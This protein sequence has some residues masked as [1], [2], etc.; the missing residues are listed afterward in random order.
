MMTMIPVFRSLQSCLR[1]LHFKWC[2]WLLIIPGICS[3]SGAFGQDEAHSGLQHRALD[4]LSKHCLRCHSSDEAAGEFSLQ[5][6]RELFASGYVEPGSVENSHLISV[7][8]PEGDSPPSMPKTGSALTNEEVEWLRKWIA[9]GAPFP[10]TVRLT[11]PVVEDFNWWSLRP[12]KSPAVPPGTSSPPVHPIDAFIQKRLVEKGL[13]PSAPADRR[14]LIRRLSYDL[15]GLP[16]TP[17]EIEAFEQDKGADA[18][19][20]LTERLLNSPRYGERWGRHWLDVVKYADTCG[21]DKDKLRPNAWP[22]RDY[23]IRSFNEDKPYGRFVQEQIAGD[24]LFPGE[25]DGILGLG[26]IA[27]GPWDFIGHV[28]VPESKIDGMVARNLDRDDMVSNVMNSFCSVTIQCARCHN[29]KFDPF[30]QK[31]YY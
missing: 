27:A 4:V 26:F 23:V 14:T 5:T 9:A 1:R 8:Q 13:T 31:H 3:L 28:E 30:T 29:H 22:Y 21:Y 15:T 20:R 6:A 11:E 10:D 19:D 18:W 24:V 25:P 12:L 7:V 2:A 16:P 17:A